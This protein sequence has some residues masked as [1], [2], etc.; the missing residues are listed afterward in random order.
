MR[1]I[2][3]L[4]AAAL[5]LASPAAYAQAA[6]TG[7]W[8]RIDPAA[9]RSDSLE[10]MAGPDKRTL[11]PFMTWKKGDATEFDLPAALRTAPVL[12]LRAKSQPYEADASFCVFYGTQGVEDFYFDGIESETMRQ[13]D[14]ESRCR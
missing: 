2:P 3:G 10:L 9:T 8:I 13:T 1:Y 14:H 11:S 6:K 5:L 12:A 4:L 7:W